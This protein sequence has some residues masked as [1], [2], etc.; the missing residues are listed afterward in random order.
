VVV[1]RSAFV[2]VLVTVTE[3]PTTAAPVGSVT[4]P[5]ILPLAVAWANNIWFP[6]RTAST[7]KKYRMG[8]GCAH[9]VIAIYHSFRKKLLHSGFIS[10]RKPVFSIVNLMMLPYLQ[11]EILGDSKLLQ[12]N[13]R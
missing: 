11:T 5:A 13:R 3:A 9:R 4:T 7:N 6:S 2:A 8:R 1:F 10:T 12:R